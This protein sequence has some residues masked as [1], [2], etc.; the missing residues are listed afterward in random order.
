MA[1]VTTLG[2][3]MSLGRFLADRNDAF[4]HPKEKI[5]NFHLPAAFGSVRG[6]AP[7]RDSA[8]G[9]YFALA[10]L[11]PSSHNAS[12]EE[13]DVFTIDVAQDTRQRGPLSMERFQEA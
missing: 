5:S 10:A 9:R 8:A 11:T 7:A 13:T 4:R 12:V 1:L 2:C 3:R 6:L